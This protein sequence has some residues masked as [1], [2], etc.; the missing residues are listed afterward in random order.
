MS[1]FGD[2][3]TR[4]TMLLIGA[5]SARIALA[6]SPEHPLIVAQAF[7]VGVLAIYGWLSVRSINGA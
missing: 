7:L 2:R 5:T 4:W 3:F 1:G 6:V